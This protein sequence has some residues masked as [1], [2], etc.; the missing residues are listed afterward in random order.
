MSQCVYANNMPN[1]KYKNIGNK[2]KITFN[3]STGTWSKAIDKK[4]GN[5]YIKTKGFGDFYDYLNPN[6]DFA[7][8][9][10]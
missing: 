2:D 3:E 1:L 6:K 4:S 8:S 5:Y 7:F 10:N 9:T